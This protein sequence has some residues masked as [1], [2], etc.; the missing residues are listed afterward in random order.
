MGS[1]DI[2]KAYD[3]LKHV[4]LIN[5]MLKRGVSRCLIACWI[6]LL[7]G[8]KYNYI[9]DDRTASGFFSKQ[10]SVDQGD[11]AAPFQ[12]VASADDALGSI[13]MQWESERRGITLDDGT[14][15]T[16]FMF[17][18]TSWPVCTTVEDLVHKISEINEALKPAGWQLNMKD[19]HWCSTPFLLRCCWC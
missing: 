10:R 5:S 13:V 14:C 16:H 6:R 12:F 1:A 8:S 9:L 18:D 7:K 11:P 2:W 4:F 19:L 17:A 15:I 3:R